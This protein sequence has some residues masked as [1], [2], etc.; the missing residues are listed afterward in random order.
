MYFVFFYLL[1]STVQCSWMEIF[2]LC[3][4]I[5]RIFIQLRSIRYVYIFIFCSD[6]QSQNKNCA[7]LFLLL[8]F[9]N[10]AS[11]LLLPVNIPIGFFFKQF[12]LW[13]AWTGLTFF[14]RKNA[15]VKVDSNEWKH[16]FIFTIHTHTKT[17]KC[18][19]GYKQTDRQTDRTYKIHMKLCKV[20]AFY[21]FKLWNIVSILFGWL[22]LFI[23]F[24]FFFC[25]CCII[26]IRC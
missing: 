17:W 25:R 21:H 10:T 6:F 15:L 26:S 8:F 7:L 13:S 16:E 1:S 5:F 19:A 2:E 12:Q 23:P 11:F 18:S 14:K 24:S 9:S 22:F 4:T 3:A 20:N